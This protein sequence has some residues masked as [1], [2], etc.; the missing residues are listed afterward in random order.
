MTSQTRASI[1]DSNWAA[2]KGHST[3]LKFSPPPH[4]GVVSR[5]LILAGFGLLGLS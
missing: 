5:L 1:P 3:C 2:L 4:L